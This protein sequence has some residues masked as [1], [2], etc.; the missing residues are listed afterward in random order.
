MNESLVNIFLTI[1]VLLCSK[2]S[3]SFFEQID[4]E[5]IKAS[6]ECI[7]TQIILE[8]IY[9]VRIAHILRDYIPWLS[10]NFLLLANDFDASAAG[11]RTRFHDIHMAVVFSFA[12]HAEFAIIIWEEVSF[13]N[14]VEF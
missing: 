8:A 14:E 9:Q 10:L 12:V 5:W 7:Y 2:A 6:D 1:C 13:G 4:F 3:E 11:R